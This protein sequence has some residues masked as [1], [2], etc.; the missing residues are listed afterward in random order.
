MSRRGHLFI[1][2][3]ALVFAAT[4]LPLGGAAP[5]SAA[6]PVPATPAFG[7]AIDPLPRYEPET[8]CSPGD[9]PGPVSVRHLFDATYGP[10]AAGI[11]RACGPVSGHSQGRA[12]DY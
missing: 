4:G 9:K 11:S 12:L 8:G 7:P 2:L 6:V 5:A 10:H 1:T 3:F